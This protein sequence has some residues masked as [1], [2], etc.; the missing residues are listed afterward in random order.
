MAR[1]INEI[2]QIMLNKKAASNDIETLEVLT[3]NE[4]NTLSNLT[5]DSKV[6]VWRFWIYVTA[7]TIWTL[8]VLMDIFRKQVDD[9][10]QENELH[11][12]PWYKKKA[13]AFQYGQALLPDSDQYDNTGL[14][15]SEI[16]ARKIIKHVAVIRKILNGRGYLELKLA[17]ENNGQLIPLE[18]PELEAFEA[19]MFLVADA[20][21]F[22]EYISLPHDDLRLVLDIY[23]DPLVLYQDGAR[24]DGTNNTPVIEGINT[25]LYN[26]EFNGEL[27]LDKLKT[28][29]GAVEGVKIPVIRQ[30]FT[31]FGAFDYVPLDVT[32][33]ARAGY[34][35]LDTENTTINYIARE[36]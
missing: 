31:K 13:L 22:I 1:T 17:K 7:F 19:Y 35:R 32:Y 26:L 2:Q 8:E 36:I 29:I 28:F 9:L 4:K 18:V 15:V 5:S 6:S 23:Y 20:G 33:L 3:T 14:S 30:A 10:I 16:E 11:N 21:T 24:K 12:F 25:F 27:I 34:M